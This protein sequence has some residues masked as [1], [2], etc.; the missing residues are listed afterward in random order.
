MRHPS[1]AWHSGQPGPNLSF[2]H[3]E[4]DGVDVARRTASDTADGEMRINQ[5]KLG[6]PIHAAQI[7]DELV[8]SK[9]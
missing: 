8:V 6:L 5:I 9:W 3:G 2:R 1:R 4:S 7:R